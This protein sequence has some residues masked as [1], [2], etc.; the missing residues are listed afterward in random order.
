MELLPKTRV[1]LR[2][3]V[4]LGRSAL[5][6]LMTDDEVK[7]TE[8]ELPG[9]LL[10]AFAPLHRLGMGVAGGVVLGGLIF[11]MTLFLVAKGGYP[12]GP[13]MALLGQFW[14]GYTV[15]FPGAFIGLFYGFGTGFVAGWGF[16][17]I[18]N[19]A[20]WTWLTLIR[21]RAEMEEYGDFL[22]HM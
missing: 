4:C 11:L 17:V 8:E 9:P 6:A 19:L 22:D 7:K 3:S 16:A 1:E 5:D 10:L 18:R 20:V 15:T 21:S 2:V 12:I 14:L 13:T